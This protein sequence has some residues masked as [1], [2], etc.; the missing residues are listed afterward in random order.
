VT[1]WDEFRTIDWP[2]LANLVE[3]PLILDGRNMFKAS[4]VAAHGFHY[5][6]IGR[7]PGAPHP[8]VEAAGSG[9]LETES[10][11]RTA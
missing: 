2:R 3:R 7:L 8:D 1:E 9:L 4:D 11:H 5:V 6:S 10:R